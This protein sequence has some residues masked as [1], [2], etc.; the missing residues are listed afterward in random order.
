MS[1]V[2]S[3][4]VAPACDRQQ[5]PFAYEDTFPGDVIWVRGPGRCEPFLVLI[6]KPY[7]VLL[8]FRAVDFE[9]DQTTTL[10]TY[11][12]HFDVEAHHHPKPEEGV[13]R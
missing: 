1:L 3:L 2:D 8:L 7:S 6:T 10:Q 13:A 9:G 11:W 12:W 5:K 4:A